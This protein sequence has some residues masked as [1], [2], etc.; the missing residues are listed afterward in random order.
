MKTWKTLLALIFLASFGLVACSSQPAVV[1]P[2]STALPPVTPTADWK[3]MRG[4][5]ISIWL[6]S[7]YTGGDLGKDAAQI[8]QELQA[9]GS[10]FADMAKSIKDNQAKY[11]LFAFDPKA[12]KAANLTYAVAG[13]TFMPSDQSMEAL[14]NELTTQL[15]SQYKVVEQKQVQYERYSAGR[16]I[17]ELTITDTQKIKEAM[18]IIKDGNSLWQ[19]LFAAPSSQFDQRLPTFEQSAQTATF[20]PVTA[21]PSSTGGI[22][23]QTL[24]TGGMVL[25]GA[26]LL[27]NQ[28]RKRQR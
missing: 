10:D 17:V 5:G 22:S 27:L 14:M 19:I 1:L 20:F 18:Y 8:S 13:Y 3:E 15:P 2:T 4:N 28:W 12:D 24:L 11:S 6:P 7:Q 26:G 21:Q 23:T 16:V 25:V 9:L